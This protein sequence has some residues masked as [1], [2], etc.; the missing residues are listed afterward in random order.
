MARPAA[1]SLRKAASALGID[2]KDAWMV[3]R[4]RDEMGRIHHQPLEPCG[5]P[6]ASTTD[7]DFLCSYTWGSPK[8]RVPDQIGTDSKNRPLPTIC[9]PGDAPRI[10]PHNLPKRVPAQALHTAYRDANIARFRLAPW[11]P[12]FRALEIMRPDYRLNDVDLIINRNALQTLLLF[13]MYVHHHLV[14]P[15][16]LPIYLFANT[17]ATRLPQP[18]AGEKDHF[19]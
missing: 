11:R 14:F 8:T 10:L 6:V 2:V 9:V 15:S 19:A 16:S 12:M 3:A 1:I 13:G 18:M 17:L 5:H 4:L 7:F